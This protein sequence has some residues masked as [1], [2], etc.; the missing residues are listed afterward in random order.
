MV[1]VAQLP[2]DRVLFGAQAPTAGSWREWGIERMRLAL[3]RRPGPARLL[4]ALPLRPADRRAR[5]R[6][7]PGAAGR[8]APGAVRGAGLGDLRAADRVRARGGDPA[9]AG[10]PA[11]APLPAHRPA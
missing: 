9:P 1:R 11:R 2:A 10:R 4:R 7:N 6:A 8:R 3:G 5:V